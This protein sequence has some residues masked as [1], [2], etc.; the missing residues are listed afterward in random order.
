M[1][2]T[3]ESIELALH[4]AEVLHIYTQYLAHLDEFCNQGDNRRVLLPDH[5]PEVNDRARQTALCGDISVATIG[6][7]YNV[8]ESSS[9]D[10]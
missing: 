5:P 3:F 1:L 4:N 9:S 8:K 7:L 6:D 10:A 2:L